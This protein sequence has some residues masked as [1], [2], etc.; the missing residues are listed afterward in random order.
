LHVRAVE[1]FQAAEL[2]ERNVAPCEFDLKRTTVTGRSKQHSLL[3]Q[4]RADLTVAQ[5]LLDDVARLVGFIADG[6][7]LRALC[8]IPLGPEILGEPLTREIDHAIGSGQDRLRRT[9]VAIKRNDFRP[10]TKGVWEVEDVAN[11]RGT[12]GIDRLGIITDYG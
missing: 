4:G 9:I 5:H 1:E 8:R 12:E 10:R 7:E 11:R 2:H 3:L 6:D